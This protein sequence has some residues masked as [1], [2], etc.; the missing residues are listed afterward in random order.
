MKNRENYKKTTLNIFSFE[1]VFG[2]F[3]FVDPSYLKR[4]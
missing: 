2:Y 1:I 3:I 4:K